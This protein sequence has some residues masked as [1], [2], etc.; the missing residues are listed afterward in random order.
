MPTQSWAQNLFVNKAAIVEELN[1]R[2]LEFEEVNTVLLDQG[3]DIEN[4]NPELLTQD[5]I[6]Q[7]EA[8]I[9]AL[10]T[11]KKQ[12]DLAQEKERTSQ[13]TVVANT[14]SLP[15]A[16]EILKTEPLESP[17]FKEDIFG[18]G[19]FRNKVI[20]VYQNSNEINA[21]SSYILGPGDEVI[22][23]IWGRSQL[24]ESYVIEA[25][26]F[27]TVADGAQRIYLRGLSL[28]D[29]RIKLR[30]FFSQIY[31]FSAGEFNVALNYS[32]TVKINIYGEVGENPGS[33]TISAF[34]SA[35]NA[36]ALVKGTNDIGSL[37]KIQL[38]KASGESLTM[39]VY[40]L[41]RNPAIQSKYFLEENDVI[42]IPVADNIVTVEGGVKRPLKYEMVKGEGLE[43]LFDFCGGFTEYAYPEKVQIKRFIDGQQT[44]TD[45]NWEEYKASNKNFMLEN[46]D[47]VVVSTL[48]EKIRNF[49]EVSGEV[50]NPGIYERTPDMTVRALIEK[51]GLKITSSTEIAYLTRTNPN[52]LSEILKLNLNEI[53]TQSESTDNLILKDSDQLEIWSQERFNDA[54]QISVSGSVRLPGSWPY[55]HNQ[56][57]R[58]VDAIQLAGGLTRDASNF[59]IIHKNDPLNPNV[60]SYT[61]IDNLDQLFAS[62]EVESNFVLSPFDSLVVES[63]STFREEAYVRIEGAVNR[64]GTYL[65]G[66]NM[67]IKDLMTLAGG[68]KLAASTENIEISRVIIQNNQPTKTVVDKIKLDRAFNTLSGNESEFVLEPY[69]N[70]AVRFVNDFH[71]QQ[72]VFLTGEVK[73]P[74]PYAIAQDNERISSV[75]SRAGGV[76]AEAFPPGATLERVEGDYGSVV[77]KLDDIINNPGSEF[78]FVVKNGDVIDVPKVREFVTIKGATKAQEVVGEASINEGNEIHVP[79]HEGKDAMFYINEYAGGLS[80]FA[81]RNKVFVEYAN[82]EIKKPRNGFLRKRY[83]K[84]KQG[85]IIS[86]GY[87]PVPVENEESTSD[88]DWTKVLG[89]S[90]AQAMSI[91]TLILLI[92]RLD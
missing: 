69:D 67:T 15:E 7:I 54:M 18:Q 40:E 58:V 57:I 26:G 39:D 73:Y 27:I 2:G 91:L 28:E 83:A 29:A 24:D 43:E 38:Q 21:P 13:N 46:G 81:D 36:L 20:N 32:R 11:N 77:I 41:L 16:N 47:V 60:K 55:D 56:S 8:T 48:D 37:R 14:D 5:Q 12:E 74:G 19:L 34:N 1:K 92:Q 49:V 85:S 22:V 25:N 10:E 52:G 23:S 50:L 76:T 30:R 88:V 82:G 80:D 31:S 87:K 63:K 84:V 75:I 17:G 42:L 33:F 65:Y 62:P 44:I 9:L 45:L 72:R 70:V 89:D 66:D 68:F 61:T 79:F 4:L 86:V 35:F 90:V 64:P 78:N 6:R 71:L 51:A 59:A 3:I 53:L